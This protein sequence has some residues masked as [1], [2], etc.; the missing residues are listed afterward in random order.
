MGRCSEVKLGIVPDQGYMPT[1]RS[2][3]CAPVTDVTDHALCGNRAEI[4]N[5]QHFP[6]ETGVSC[7]STVPIS[8]A[9]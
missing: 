6:L 5:P 4:K 2:A 1:L 3:A 8:S 7:I 9:A